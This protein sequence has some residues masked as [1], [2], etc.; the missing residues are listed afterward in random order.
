MLCLS[1]D[2][3][4]LLDIRKRLSSIDIVLVGVERFLACT[5]DPAGW[6]LRHEAD[7]GMEFWLT[8]KELHRGL[9][10]ATVRVIRNGEGG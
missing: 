4:T 5:T 3:P 8:H 10:D 1:K 2:R 6:R 7:P 9:A